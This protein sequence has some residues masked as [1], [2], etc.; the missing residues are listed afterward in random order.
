[1]LGASEVGGGEIPRHMEE[2]A[3]FEGR[4]VPFYFLLPCGVSEAGQVRRKGF[5]LPC[6]ASRG[7]VGLKEGLPPVR[8]K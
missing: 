6:G 3:R 4:V 7:N 8:G 5:L 2:W 1:V